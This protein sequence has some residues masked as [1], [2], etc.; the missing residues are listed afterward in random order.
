MGVEPI[1]P[2]VQET[3]P[4][5]WAPRTKERPVGL[6]PTPGVWRTSF[7]PLEHGRKRAPRT[8]IEPVYAR[9][10]TEQH[11][12]TLDAGKRAE[13]GGIE[14]LANRGRAPVSTR[15]RSRDRFTLQETEGGGHAPHARRAQTAFEAAPV[16]DRFSFQERLNERK[17][18]VSNP[19]RERARRFPAEPGP[20]PV[21]LPRD[22]T[23]GTRGRRST[24]T[25]TGSWV[26]P[27]R[28]PTRPSSSTRPG[29][30]GQRG[31]A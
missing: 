30:C 5:R 12:Q 9:E 15:A 14:P 17:A 27:S 21:H 3:A 19:T 7:L 6:E 25:S 26:T 24:R 16:L 8:G 29:R 1:T 28:S 11:P 4:P 22:W 23:E 13:S 2:S 31:S 10:T 18:E 20:R